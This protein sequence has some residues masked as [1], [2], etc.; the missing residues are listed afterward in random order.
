MKFVRTISDEDRR[1]LYYLIR[2]SSN[3]RIRQRAHAIILSEKRF[4]VEIISGIHD[5]HRD[6]VSRWIDVWEE[7]GINGLFDLPK[8]GR[9]KISSK[10]TFDTVNVQQIFSF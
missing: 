3:Y 1:D 10:S 9:P 8:S 2:T 7:K 4:P 6:T 5:V